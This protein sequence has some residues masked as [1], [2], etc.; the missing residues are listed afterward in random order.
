MEA[1]SRLKKMLE[2][3]AEIAD[4]ITINIESMNVYID[5]DEEE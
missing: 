3:A 1:E 5:G 2:L 4:K